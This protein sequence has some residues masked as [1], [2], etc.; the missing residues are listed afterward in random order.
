MCAEC[1]VTVTHS[2]FFLELWLLGYENLFISDKARHFKGLHRIYFIKK[3]V[4]ILFLMNFQIRHKDSEIENFY[5][6]IEWEK[7]FDW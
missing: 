7:C 6:V 5:S 2:K 4:H 1:Y 3:M